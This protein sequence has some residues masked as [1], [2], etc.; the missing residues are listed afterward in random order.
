MLSP[1]FHVC[2]SKKFHSVERS[3]ISDADCMPGKDTCAVVLNY[4]CV[5][6]ETILRECLARR[7]WCTVLGGVDDLQ[8]LGKGNR[9]TLQFGDFENIEWEPVMAGTHDASSYLVRKGLSRKAQ[10]CLQ[11]K[12]FLSKHP[13][14]V[15]KQ[16]FPTSLIIETWSAFED[17]RFDFG[18]GA[19]ASFDTS[20]MPAMPLREKLNWC[21]DNQ[22]EEFERPERI[23]WSWILKPS[24]TNKGTDISIVHDWEELLDALEETPDIREWV[25]QRYVERPLLVQGHKF[26]LR[27]YI[28][29]IGALKVYMFERVLMLLAAHKYDASVDDPYSHLTNTARGVEDDSFDEDL[30]VQ[31]LDDLPHHLVRERPD[32]APDMA[33]A[34]MHT[35]KIRKDMREQIGDLFAA[36]ENEYTIFAPMSN[37]F[38]LYGLDFLVD[39]TLGVH[40][41]EVNPGPDFKQTGDRL[42][43][44]IA[45]LMEQTCALVIDDKLFD[46]SSAADQHENITGATSN[47]NGK[48]SENG[49]RYVDDRKKW[50]TRDFTRV[51]D[52]QWSA[53][54]M[55]GGMQF[56]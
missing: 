33:H 17:I 27:V 3:A 7:P 10:L 37:C 36:Y 30:C 13:D 32:L 41:L 31:L 50:N 38:E 5:Y 47:G 12:R 28:I 2:P 42:K 24:V 52:K 51:Y 23:D 53:A 26:H 6:T 8:K 19:I 14:S 29:C 11:L 55:K 9:V 34:N 15:L 40:L 44:V 1:L 20:T 35:E 39:E 4:N 49:R 21:L 48:N 22:L 46:T 56:S 18:R 45:E 16:G 25:L 43:T 54:N